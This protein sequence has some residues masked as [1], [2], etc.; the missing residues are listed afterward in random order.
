MRRYL[1]GK[2]TLIGVATGFGLT[3]AVGVAVVL[4]ATAAVVAGVTAGSGGG[5][6][7]QAYIPPAPSAALQSGRGRSTIPEPAKAPER[8]RLHQASARASAVR[9]A[10]GRTGRAAFAVAG[11]DGAIRGLNEHELFQSASVVKS[12]I[13]A[14]ELERLDREG[15]ALDRATRATLT[16]MIVVSDNDAATWVYDRV[17]P[18]GVAAIAHRVGMRDLE[19]STIWGATRVSAADM[20]LMFSDL[21]RIMPEQF[22]RF[23]KGLLGSI[24]PEQSWGI[25]A[26]AGQRGWRVRFK[27]GWRLDPSGQV[28]NQAAEL[29][30]NGSTIAMV[31]L[32]DGAPSM[33]YGIETVEGIATRLL[34]G[35]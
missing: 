14:A 31:V 3:I 17:G 2:R 23:G 12:L 9:F 19:T 8:H 16:A 26:V 20:A 30:R 24:A 29:S 25:P 18:E 33:P 11:A 6:A 4:A 32:S 5:E 35:G 22:E 1:I 27:G 28:V 10:A 21:D 34:G 15:L 7:T 13:L